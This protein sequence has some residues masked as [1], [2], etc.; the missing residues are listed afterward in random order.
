MRDDQLRLARDLKLPIIATN[1][2]HYTYRSDAAAH[3]ILLCV[4]TGKTMADPNRFKLD[5]DGYY[6]KSPAEMRSLW[7]D[8]HDLREACDNTLLIAERCDV[9]F[10]EGN[11]TYMSRFP[12]P[13]GRDRAELVPQG[14]R[15]R[16]AA[17]LPERHP[18]RSA[19]AGRLR[20]RRHLADELPRL[21]PRG[22]GLHQLGQGPRHP[23]RSG[24]RIRRGLDRRLRD[25]HHRPEPARARAD[26][27][28]LPQP[29]PRVHARLRHRL[30][31]APARRGHPLRHRA[32]RQRPR[33]ADRHLRHDQGQAG[34]EGRRARARLPVLD[35]RADHQGHAG[36]GDGQGRPAREDLRPRARALQGGRR[37][38]RAVRGGPGGREGR[39]DRARASRGSSGSGACTRPA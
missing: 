31:R 35:G 1:D 11:G 16:S 13:D 26:L 6:L 25:A 33:R 24:P 14:G 4:G 10:T 38:P 9:S 30:R 7:A 12:V 27:R 5:G 36:R 29:R 3:E 32:L 28:A 34:R 17:A 22:R 2:S 15:R 18:G 8:K 39:R 21:L 20:G 19:A 23:G 37:V